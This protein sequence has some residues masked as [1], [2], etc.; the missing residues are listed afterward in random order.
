[1]FLYRGCFFSL[2]EYEFRSKMRF[3]LQPV[4]CFVLLF[5]LVS[6]KANVITPCFNYLLLTTLRLENT[7]D[8]STCV[9]YRLCCI[10]SAEVIFAVSFQFIAENMILLELLRAVF[11]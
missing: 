3:Y 1:M 6:S 10:S 5:L 11:Y 7:N 9:K 8:P 2:F 4:F